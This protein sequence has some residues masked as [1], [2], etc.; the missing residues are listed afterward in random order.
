MYSPSEKAMPIRQPS[1]ANLMIDSEDGDA[2]EQT[3]TRRLNP[4]FFQISRPQSLLNGFFTRIGTTEVVLEWNLPNINEDLSNNWLEFDISGA[5]ANP[6][7]IYIPT[8]FYT[9][10][11]LLNNW[12]TEFNSSTPATMTIKYDASGASTTAYPLNIDFGADYVLIQPSPLAYQLG[13]PTGG[14]FPPNDDV[15]IINP[16]LRAYRYID[17][18]S[19]Q[20]TYNQDLKDSA[21]NKIVRDVLCRW[22]MSW[23]V[24]TDKDEYGFPIDMGLTPF[25]ARRL[26]N[27]PKQIR[28]DNSQPIGVLAFEVYGTT[29]FPASA[30]NNTLVVNPDYDGRSNWLMTLQVSEV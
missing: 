15:Y 29:T 3:G 9:V 8:G 2:K 13:L 26:Y 16:D 7:R 14:Y 20:L 22:Y 11:Q 12:Q 1:T 25:K 28:W 30:Y 6:Y 27:P 10:S 19:S 4:W 18:I 21:T 24:P 23:D 5:P 17:F